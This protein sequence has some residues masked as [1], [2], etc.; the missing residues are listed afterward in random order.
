MLTKYP[1]CLKSVI[2]SGC[3]ERLS[4]NAPMPFCYLLD[5]LLELQNAETKPVEPAELLLRF[6]LVAQSESPHPY[7]HF[8]TEFEAQDALS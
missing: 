1:K 5:A 3:P 7:P 4:L 2:Y 6:I 8:E